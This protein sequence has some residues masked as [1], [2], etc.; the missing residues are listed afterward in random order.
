MAS[1]LED[2]KITVS[3]LTQSSEPS[4][5]RSLDGARHALGLAPGYRVSRS[6]V[7]DWLLIIEQKSDLKIDANHQSDNLL[8]LEINSVLSTTI[9]KQK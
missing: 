8:H 4:D 9:S 7:V 3:F 5:H 1:A 2:V 6:L